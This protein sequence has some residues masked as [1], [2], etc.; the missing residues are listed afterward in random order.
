MSAAITIAELG[1][2]VTLIDENPRVGGQIYRQPHEPV[3]A[4][5]DP[6]DD[7]IAHQGKTLLRRMEE[8]KDRIELLSDTAVWAL[9]PPKQVATIH[10]GSV[11]IIEA[12][13]LVVA[14]GAYEYVPPFPGWTLP[15]VMTP[16]GAQTLV[17][18]MKVLPGR[19]VL[20]AGTGPFLLVVA[21]QL[22]NAGME[23]AGVVEAVRATELVAALPRLLTDSSKVWQGWRYIRKLKRAGIPMYN[24]SVIVEAQGDNDVRRALIAPCNRQWI[25]DR[26]RMVTVGV[27]TLCVGYGFVPRTE[28]AQL[29]GCNMQF[30]N[31]R[32][33]WTPEVGEDLETSVPGLW[34]PGDG[35]GVAGAVAAELEG[36]LVGLSVACKLGVPGSRTLRA[37]RRKTRAALRKV[38]RFR[39]GMDRLCEVRPGLATLATA[40]T[41]ACRCEEVTLAEVETSITLGGTDIRTLKA[42]TRLGM[43]PCQGRV[44]WPAVSRVIASRK[45]KPVADI[46]PRSVRAPIV[47]L[48]LGSLADASLSDCAP[49]RTPNAK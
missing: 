25:P 29:A 9:F 1:L 22:H 6:P 21:L 34:T 33:G 20:L 44:C 24:G 37:R 17:K 19:R 46:G 43:G 16:G 42:M 11:S 40:E 10:D 28:L 36:T 26:S 27:D 30:D 39:K 8:L 18:T 31:R 45:K 5:Q 4:S 7:P 13:Q 35:G 47:P 2:P 15:G 49:A 3:Q 38:L 32:G 23:V 41:L 14:P 48:T 12:E